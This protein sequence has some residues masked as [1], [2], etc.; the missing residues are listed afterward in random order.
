MTLKS[1]S[2][3]TT[4]Y[5]KAQRTLEALLDEI[6]NDE[7]HPLADLLDYLS[8]Q[9]EAYRTCTLTFRRPPYAKC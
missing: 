5:A 4:D 2:T 1:H 7:G 8:D 9:V 6:G 3:E